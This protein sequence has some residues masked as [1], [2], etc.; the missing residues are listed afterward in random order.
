MIGSVD[1]DGTDGPSTQ[2]VT[3]CDLPAL[4]GGIVDGQTVRRARELGVDLREELRR[5]NTT[6]ALCRLGDGVIATPNISM[7]D[8]SVALVLP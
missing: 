4:D 2:F 8:L 6:T 7:N 1:S 3:D 5:H